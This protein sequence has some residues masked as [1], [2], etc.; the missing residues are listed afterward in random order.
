MGNEP[1]LTEDTGVGTG[2]PDRGQELGARMGRYELQSMIGAGGMGVVFAARDPELDRIVAV[3]VLHAS[4]SSSAQGALRL[5]R[6]GQTMARLTHPNVIRVYDVGEAHGSLFVAMEYIAGDTLQR[7]LARQ[8]RTPDEIFATFVL[9]GRG[10]A[11]AHA[12]GLVH[13]DFK[14]SNVLVGDDG[15]VLVTDFGLARSAHDD[16]DLLSSGGGTSGSIL[17][18]I[19]AAG[20]QPGTPAFM[21]P[22]QHAGDT[23]DERADQFSFCVALWTALFDAPPYPGRTPEQLRA[24]TARGVLT[25][26]SADVAARVPRRVRDAIERGLRPAPRDRH[27]S[28]NDLLAE[29][30]PPPRPA[31]AAWA[32]AAVA[33]IAAG[34]IA[35]TWAIRPAK[36]EPCSGARR[37]I[38]AVWGPAERSAVE[39]AFAA[40]GVAFAADAGA[41]AF[42]YLDRWSDRWVQAHTEVCRAT[43]VDRS[44]SERTMDLRIACLERQ[45]AYLGTLVDYFGQA[46]ADVVVRSSELALGLPAQTACDDVASLAAAS[47]AE[48]DDAE[49]E[50]LER[51]LDE[52]E[53]RLAA[54]KYDEGLP[55]AAEVLAAANQRHAVALAAR[56]GTTLGRLQMATGVYEEGLPTLFR[57]AL[58]AQITH[59]PDVEVRAWAV[60]LAI[61]AWRNKPE[62]EEAR[63][64]ALGD[65]AI[66]RAPAPLW[67]R[68]AGFLHNHADYLDHTLRRPWQAIPLW[69]LALGILRHHAPS[70]E[71]AIASTLDSL[72]GAFADVGSPD[73][74]IA[75][76]REALVMRERL[77]GPEHPVVAGSMHNLAARLADV[78]RADEAEALY[79]R[80]LALKIRTLGEHHPRVSNTLIEYGELLI[81][82]GR[83]DEGLAMAR[84]DVELW[85]A[86]QGAGSPEA[87]D[88]RRA[89][90]DA[91]FITGHPEDALAEYR[92]ARDAFLAI[93]DA[94]M[95]AEAAGV[96]LAMVRPL[97]ALDRLDEAA[98]AIATFEGSPT[99]PL[100]LARA[101][102]ALAR[103]ALGEARREV[104]A[105]NALHAA[106]PLQRKWRQAELFLLDAEV[107][108]AAGETDAARALAARVRELCAPQLCH[109][110]TIDDLARA[111]AILKGH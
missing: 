109:D 67:S 89:L 24:S 62:E 104:D 82:A 81:T 90:G 6:E 96:S 15:R 32:L 74:G 71:V 80:A 20:H 68:Q 12:A 93:G 25:R 99:I 98:A 40:T 102:L 69:S 5:R 43:R 92:R 44:Q 77:F 86:D 52:A 39:R 83:F 78:G 45:R 107:H 73:L 29:L 97:I 26:P 42:A 49:L 3:K 56:A 101:R 88:S 106:T 41:R 72:G 9:A 85:A 28:M 60:T 50:P 10:V 36:A 35:A 46:D 66:R 100:H 105:A 64:Y 70:D 94:E 65:A 30:A 38:A 55:I 1:T 8:A 57:A 108:Q 76:Q 33:V 48:V 17:G 58:D 103:H 11:A 27:P 110:W 91:L 54:G 47:P 23:V 2:E 34:A 14:P 31:R 79:V 95:K 59:Q 37:E 19:T 111:D 16:G 87:A 7:W 22:E 21:A 13:R 4:I 63:I 61:M 51:R 53:L 75:M 18:T 84:R